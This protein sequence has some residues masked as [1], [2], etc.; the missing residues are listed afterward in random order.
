MRWLNKSKNRKEVLWVWVKKRSCIIAISECRKY[1]DKGSMVSSRSNKGVALDVKWRHLHGCV[2]TLA[3]F[4][5]WVRPRAG[6]KSDLIRVR[7]FYKRE[8]CSNTC[9][10]QGFFKLVDMQYKLEKKEREDKAQW[11]R[12]KK[13][14]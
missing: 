5:S 8:Q 1:L 6:R 4:S 9:I 12:I 7:C 10:R 3:I 2:F 14:Q 11:R 13:I